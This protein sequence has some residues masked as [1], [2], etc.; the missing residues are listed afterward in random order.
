MPD[1]IVKLR[2]NEDF[3]QCCTLLQSRKQK[4]Q[5]LKKFTALHL[6]LGE[7]QE[8]T[9]I[10]DPGLIERVD[11]DITLSIIQDEE[12]ET[13]STANSLW[14]MERI[15]ATYR[16]VPKRYPR[17]KAAVLDTGLS[18]H[19][20]LAIA[21]K[22]ANFSTEKTAHDLNGHGTH[23]AGTIGGFPA[24]KTLRHFHGVYP[25]L[26][27]MSVK[28]FAKD[29][30]APLSAIMKAIEWCINQNVKLINMSFGI[31]EH[32]ASLYEVIRTAYE[33]GVIIV[34]ASGNDG[35]P[36]LKYPARYP[37]VISVGSI[38]EDGQV[39][40]FSQFGTHLDVVAPG[41]NILSTWPKSQFKSLSGTSMAC[42]HVTGVL[43]L[44]L[45]VRADLTPDE[46]KQLLV[47]SAE[48]LPTSPLLQG[49]GLVSVTNVL[50]RLRE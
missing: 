11:A 14:G 22:Y 48:G 47:E 12:T 31:D 23:L 49:H 16:S 4:Y 8:V 9:D 21:P 35:N 3:Q 25:R 13:A 1:V 42:A 26:P 38:N 15:G 10:V 39:S 50:K 30:T 17:A 24:R 7:G 46:A 28:A 43:A 37:E 6:S 29:G 32:N 40:S 19:P 34:A 27:L 18:R 20:A 36:G 41:E 2:T 45:A 44:M 5:P 33:E